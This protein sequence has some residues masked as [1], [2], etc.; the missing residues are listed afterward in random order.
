MDVIVN[1][2]LMWTKIVSNKKE[3]NETN[4][5]PLGSPFGSPLGP[6]IGSPLG[7]PLGSDPGSRLARSSCEDKG[8]II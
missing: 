2:L 4:I 3:N 8:V 7:S 1:I 6:P 5:W